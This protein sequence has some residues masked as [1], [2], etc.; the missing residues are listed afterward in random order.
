MFRFGIDD[1]TLH[2]Q[3]AQR[4]ETL[5]KREPGDFHLGRPPDLSHGAA[6]K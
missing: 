4:T 6:V 1:D 2:A 3:R 5:K